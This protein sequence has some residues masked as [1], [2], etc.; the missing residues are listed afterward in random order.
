M[1]LKSKVYLQKIQI[2]LNYRKKVT[3]NFRPS[4][5]KLFISFGMRKY[6]MRIG[7][8]TT[9]YFWSSHAK[10]FRSFHLHRFRFSKIMVILPKVS[11]RVVLM[12][13]V[14]HLECRQRKRKRR[15]KSQNV[16][17]FS[18]CMQLIFDKYNKQT[19]SFYI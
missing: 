2:F 15:I 17:R 13:R 19:F 14:I 6:V 12:K 8:K 4:L 7:S 11:I 16:W 3:Q 1:L 9:T 18:G 5:W 10:Y